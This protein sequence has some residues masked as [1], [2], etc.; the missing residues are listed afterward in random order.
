M[1]VTQLVDYL[2]EKGPYDEPAWSTTSPED[3]PSLEDETSEEGPI[4][5]ERKPMEGE[6]TE[7]NHIRGEEEPRR[8]LRKTLV[9]MN[10]RL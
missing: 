9:K 4:D 8:T 2:R 6:D 3:T 10:K 5:D 1:S 7:E